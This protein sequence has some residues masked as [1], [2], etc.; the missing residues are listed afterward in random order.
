M[1]RLLPLVIALAAPAGAAGPPAPE[2]RAEVDFRF[3]PPL[4]VKVVV[5][6]R[7]VRTRTTEGSTEVLREESMQRTEGRFEA[8]GDGRFVYAPRLVGAWAR[9]NGEPI[10]DPLPSRLGRVHAHYLIDAQGQAQEVHGDAAAPVARERSEWDSRYAHFAGRRFPLGVATV[11][12]LRVVLPDGATAEAEATT[13]VTGW[14]DCPPARC[15]LIEQ[16]YGT[17]AGGAPAT[18]RRAR[19][20]GLVSRLIEPDTMRIHGERAAHATE[21]PVPSRDGGLAWVRQTEL[22]EYDYRYLR[23]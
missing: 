7:V 17:D 20:H 18:P 14:E 6:Q 8:L 15:V 13:T 4:G 23:D 5:S 10:D 19:M 12:P 11:A 2:P 9:R 21:M 22:I 3:A 16:R 1:R